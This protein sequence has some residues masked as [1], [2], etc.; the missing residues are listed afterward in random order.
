MDSHGYRQ[1]CLRSR[2]EEGSKLGT[3]EPKSESSCLQI[4]PGQSAGLGKEMS[5]DLDVETRIGPTIVYEGAQKIEVWKAVELGEEYARMRL[6]FAEKS[7]SEFIVP[8]H[9][10]DMLLRIERDLIRLKKSPRA[11]LVE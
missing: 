3:S 7:S 8:I 1:E 6:Q 11:R 10:Y 2:K 5:P 9:I 4:L